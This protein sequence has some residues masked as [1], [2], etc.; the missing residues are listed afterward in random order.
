M[1]K[2]LK[3]WL[4]DWV[5]AHQRREIARLQQETI[6]LK[7]ELERETGVPIQ[8]TPED[9]RRLAEKAIGIDPETLKQISV[10]DPEYLKMPDR[11]TDSTDNR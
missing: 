3:Q 8:L 6:R 11:E 1:F 2:R 5:E 4:F 7:E 9:R 10:F